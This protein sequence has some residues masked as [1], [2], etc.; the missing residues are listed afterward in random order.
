MSIVARAP[1]VS[2]FLFL[3]GGRPSGR[4]WRLSRSA[5]VGLASFGGATLVLCAIW[6]AAASFKGELPGPVAT[7]GTFWDLVSNPFYDNGP[8]DKGIGLQLLASLRRVFIGFSIGTAIAVPL[9]I[10]IGGTPL[11]R[12]LLDP[13]VQVM[14]PVSPLAWY[15]IG[16]AMLQ[17]T[18]QAAIFVVAVTSLWPTVVNTA[19]GVAS[20]PQAQ[21][22]VARVFK[23]SRWKYLT[24]VVVP[25]SLPY[26]VTGLRL[27]MGTA[28]LVIVAAEMLSGST[29]IGF[30]VWDSWNSSNLERI[31][32]AI[33][34]IGL[35][36]L[37]LDRVF[38]AVAA[39]SSYQEAS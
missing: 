4:T 6:A 18:P 11:F 1:G 34:L 19:Q 28:W 13:I 16:L 35:T 2:R 33:L 20:I 26:M 8:N 39:R 38:G 5:A 17:S 21:R 31:L 29:G 27:S 24:L 37:V 14:R 10:L 23:F 12:R 22:D 25:H 7:S 15:P 32:S 3:A 9:G 36:G 30:F